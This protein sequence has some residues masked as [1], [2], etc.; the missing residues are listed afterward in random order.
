M[1]AQGGPEGVSVRARVA[2]GEEGERLW[3]QMGKLYPP[4]D[5]HQERAGARTI[6]VVALDLVD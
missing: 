5:R 3:R 2:E 1:R 4:Y 6:P